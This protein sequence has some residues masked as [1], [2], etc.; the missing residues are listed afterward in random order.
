[1]SQ[2]IQF[3]SGAIRAGDCISSGWELI[4]QQYWLFFG[5][6]FLTFV[7]TGCIPILNLFLI[8]PVL[9]GVFII[10]FVRMRQQPIDFGMMFKGFEKFVPLMVIGLIQA[11]PG[12]ITQ[13]VRF[14]LDMGEI[15]RNIMKA[16]GMNIPNANLLAESS[17]DMTDLG[18]SVALLSF[19]LIFGIVM[20]IFG[21]VWHITF[22]FAIP[23]IAD[24]D[25][26]VMDAIKLSARAGWSNIGGL[27]L[28]AILNFFV[29][30]LGVLACGIGI[31][32]AL[33]ILYASNAVAYRQVF[34]DVSPQ[35]FNTPPQP[36]VYGGM[37]GQQQM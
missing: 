1:M 29:M 13:G 35:S 5:V 22:A 15:M 3:N 11:I 2:N 4:K 25:I 31:F 36:N 33:P 7:I 34:P 27:I 26:A 19:L 21:I 10:H 30:L 6:A 12:I 14:T 37:Y 24:K 32:F 23:L 8:G 20:L 16:R 18:I 28:L 9:G 17:H